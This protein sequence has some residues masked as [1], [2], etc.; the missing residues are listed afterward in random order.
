M[1]LSIFFLHLVSLTCMIPQ[2]LFDTCF[3]AL[4]I[5]YFH[6][7]RGPLSEKVAQIRR[8]VLFFT[9]FENTS[10]SDTSANLPVPV[11]RGFDY[12]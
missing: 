2:F 11:C 4:K 5:L 3:T 1:N 9:V 7:F 12:T 8:F 10:I 6:V